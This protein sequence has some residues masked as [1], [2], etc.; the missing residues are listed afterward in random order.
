MKRLEQPGPA[1]LTRVQGRAAALRA[2]DVVLPAGV[3]LLQSIADV[4][5]AHGADSA[6]LSFESA[7]LSP[8]AFVMPALS[9]E[10]D[11]VAYFSE[12]HEAHGVVNVEGGCITF[13]QKDGQPWFHAHAHWR[14]S[15]GV[16]QGGHLLPNECQLAAPL[17]VRIWL[18]DGAAFV[19]QPDAE[20]NFSLFQVVQEPRR[21]DGSDALV[22]LVRPN[23][24]LCQALEALCVAN[25]V[26]RAVIR[27]GVGSL[28]GASFSDGAI[29][30]PPMTE[31]F[32]RAGR[33]EPDDSGELR[34]NIVVGLVDNLG[35][36]A[37]GTL[38]RG[39]NPVLITFEI[40]IEVLE[41]FAE[42]H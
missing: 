41:R 21:G 4:A 29:V 32:I 14:T 9:A 22:A 31:A 8:L 1:S 26:R 37:T 5:Y 12:R 17:P 3:S 39:D 6:V 11:H 28:I 18:L 36:L 34:S 25:G 27:G 20:T 35:Q 2:V 30:E 24:D 33:I 38:R 16:L 15:T 7:T 23:E 42:A 19:V 40:V 10:P 13:G